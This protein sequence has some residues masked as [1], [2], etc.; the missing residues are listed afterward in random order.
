M[1]QI[2]TAICSFGL[3]GK[4]F[5]APFLKTHPGFNVTMVLERT[6]EHS[7]TIF[8]TAKI[9]RNY[10][11]IL[12]DKSVELVVVNTPNALHF[13]MAKQA[14]LKNK[15]VLIEK[16]FTVELEEAEELIELAKSQKRIL[17]V[18]HNRRLDSDFRTVKKVLN[19]NLLGDLKLVE[20][21]INRWKPEIGDKHWKIGANKGS[22][23]LYDIG[24]HLIDQMLLLFGLPNSLFCDMTM[25]RPGAVVNDYFELI[26]YYD[27]MRV[28][29]KSSLLSNEPGI[30]FMLQGENAS[31]VKKGTD[32]QEEMLMAGKLPTNPKK[33]GKEHKNFTGML[34]S[35]NKAEKVVS[36]LGS[37]MD[38]YENLYQ[39]ITTGAEIRVKPEQARDVIKIIKLAEQSFKEKRVVEVQ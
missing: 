22:G 25:L 4:V 39:A 32:P 28:N 2:N 16:P 15:H 9:V 33:W 1:H 30:R 6:K 5:H 36:A 3:S 35:P 31:F 7:K 12:N 17:T 18:Y 13:D 29:L 11:Q 37:Y 21:Q 8:P 20:S 19:Q 14:L 24:S 10:E 26:L 38:F 27:K 23:H 34:Y